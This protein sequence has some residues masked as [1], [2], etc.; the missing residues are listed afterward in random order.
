MSRMREVLFEALNPLT[1]I[2]NS[3]IKKLNYIESS[4]ILKTKTFEEAKDFLQKTATYHSNS[5]D[6]LS[7]ENQEVVMQKIWNTIHKILGTEEPVSES[8]LNDE[9]ILEQKIYEFLK[10]NGGILYPLE[11]YSKKLARELTKKDQ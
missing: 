10:A 8:E 2:A 4:L 1:K 5:F 9:N 11:T 6:E 7:Q 3:I